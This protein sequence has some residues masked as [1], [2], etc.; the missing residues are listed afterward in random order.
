MISTPSVRLKSMR[1]IIC[2]KPFDQERF[3]KALDRA[4]AQISS[5]RSDALSQRILSALEEIKTSPFIW[6]DSSS[7][8][9]GHV[10]FIKARR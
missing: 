9:N 10:F 2:L 1:W 7:K 4:K 6:N 8:M 3:D 5:E